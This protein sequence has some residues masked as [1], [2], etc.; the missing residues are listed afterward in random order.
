MQAWHSAGRQ[1]ALAAGPPV[2]AAPGQ[3]TC[4]VCKY[5]LVLRHLQ[6]LGLGVRRWW[7]EASTGA[8]PAPGASVS[9]KSLFIRRKQAFSEG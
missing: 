5:V 7:E 4:V 3:L 6:S 2:L 1:G 9:L 8:A